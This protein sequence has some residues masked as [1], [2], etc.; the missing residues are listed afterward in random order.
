MNGLEFKKKH[1]VMN[2]LLFGAVVLYVLFIVT[3]PIGLSKSIY[4]TF[5]ANLLIV[6]VG[7]LSS[8]S[9]ISLNKIALY[10]ILIFLVIVPFY[11]LTSGYAPR[12][13]DLTHA[14]ILYTNLLIFL[15]CLFYLMSYNVDIGSKKS[16]TTEP[17]NIPNSKWFYS[18][19]VGCSVIS[20]ILAIGLIGFSNLFIRGE[21]Y[22]D[23][24]TFSIMIDLLIRSIPVISLSVFLW[25]KKK[26]IDLFSPVI[27]NSL[28]VL[29]GVIVFILNYPVSLSRY[30]TGAVYLGI[31]VSGFEF[32]LFKGKRFDV[33]IL[34]T[35]IVIFPIMYL[36]KFYTLEQILT[37]TNLTNINNY[38]SLDFDA[39]QMIGRT[40]RYTESV[41]LQLGGQ[42]RSVV[43]FFMPRA[44]IDLKGIPSGELV[45]SFQ[46]VS[47][48]NLSSPMVA[49][50]YIDFGVIGV[51][52]YAVVFGKIAKYFDRTVYKTDKIKNHVY[53]NEIAFPFLL[54]FSVYLY[55]GALQPSFLRLMGFFLFLIILFV[56]CKVASKFQLSD[57]FR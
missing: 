53:F 52:M 39:F 37:T 46:K 16:M 45:A 40:I 1:I 7:I 57:Q 19:L 3:N 48:I 20:L 34:V 41:G 24:G 55:R 25:T 22:L 42:L 32:S 27:M 8:R 33:L 13:M 38:N 2:F 51:M 4:L 44:I 11:Q 47:F 26:K 35:I 6:M 21:A 9:P 18:F 36:F 50:G 12:E 31:I 15:W 56:V 5:F 49:E 10:F 28:I 30:M 14:E 17:L 29:L 43:L 23:K 54:G